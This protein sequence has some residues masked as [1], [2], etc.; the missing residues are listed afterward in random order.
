MNN[1][2]VVSL[3]NSSVTYPDG[4]SEIRALDN[5]SLDLY[6]SE[7]MAVVGESGS[8]KSTLLSVIAG[9]V[10]PTSGSLNLAGAPTLDSES[11]RTELRRASTSIVFQSPNLI[12]SLTV[13]EQLVIAEH[14]RGVRGKELNAARRTA[15]E[16]LERVGLSGLGHRKV[17][18]LS[19]GQRQRVNIARALMKKPVVLLADEPTSALDHAT[20]ATMVELLAQLTKED[21]IATLMVTHDRSQLSAADRVV[22]MRDG[23]VQEITRAG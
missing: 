20:S 3:G 23:R 13:A 11:F 18:E 22:E 17:S 5:V 6:P 2:P 21:N 14:I 19:G 7:L 15:E 9:L 4:A 8:G 10:V 16:L 12:G 1:F